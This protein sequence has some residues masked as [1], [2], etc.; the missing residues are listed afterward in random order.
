MKK[1]TW[2][3]EITIDETWVEDGFDLTDERAH[4]IIMHALPYSYGHETK[5]KVIKRPPDAE[6]AKAMGYSSVDHYLARRK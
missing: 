6:V 3:V 5:A 2:T 4:D 1:F